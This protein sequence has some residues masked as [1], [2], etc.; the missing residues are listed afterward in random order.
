MLLRVLTARSVKLLLTQLQELDVIQA[1]WFN[2]YCADN[3]PTTGNAFLAALF[4]EKGV[5]VVEAT[6]QTSHAIDPQNL[7][8]RVLQIRMDM[9]ARATSA[10]PTYTELENTGVLRA[11]L[12]RSTFVSGSHEAT[13][14]KDRGRG[15]FRPPRGS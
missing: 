5:T 11:H 13:A 12:E 4:Q 3:P 10:L 14:F 9:A 6:T 2:Q 7:A 8:H 1:H 15:Y